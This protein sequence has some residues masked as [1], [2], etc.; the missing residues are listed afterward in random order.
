MRQIAGGE[1]D[2]TETG[3]RLGAILESGGIVRF[4]VGPLHSAPNVTDI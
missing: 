4:A 2:G 1:D 3:C